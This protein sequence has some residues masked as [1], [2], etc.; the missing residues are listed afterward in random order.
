MATSLFVMALFASPVQAALPETLFLDSY[1]P[2]QDGYSGPV[3]TTDPLAAG[4]FYTATVTGTYSAF[5]PSLWFP[6]EPR[7]RRICGTPESDALIPSPGRPTSR[8]GADAATTFARPKPVDAGCPALPRLRTALEIADQAPFAYRAPIG[9]QPG[10][11]NAQH[12]YRFL[13]TGNGAPAQFRL[14][15]VNV[16]DNYGVLSIKVEG[17]VVADCGGLAACVAS[18]PT[19]ASPPPLVTPP[20]PAAAICKSR[21]KFRINVRFFARDPV[22]SATIRKGSARGQ[23]LKVTRVRGR[24]GTTLSFIGNPSGRV[25]VFIFARTRSGKIKTGS[26]RY[27]LCAVRTLPL[28][29]PKL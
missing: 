13:L 14:R 16:L 8:V 12:S 21:R 29:L 15:D 18:T 1:S 23:R 9:G 7:P 20:L 22:V 11:P 10:G 5:I 26:R 28:T 17:A 27:R 2:T 24:L 6:V 4:S 25:S 3:Q 19:G